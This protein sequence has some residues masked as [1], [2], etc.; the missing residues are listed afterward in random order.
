MI[1][2]SEGTPPRHYTPTLSP[3]A[4]GLREGH[5]ERLEFV[6]VALSRETAALRTSFEGATGLL[7]DAPSGRLSTRSPRQFLSLG[8][9]TTR[10]NTYRER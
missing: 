2:H 10:S 6:D 8:E 5:R 3:L 4:G 1:V 9:P 7:S